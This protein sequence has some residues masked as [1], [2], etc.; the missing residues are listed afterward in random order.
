ML[1][2]IGGF[3]TYF[4]ENLGNGKGVNG[5]SVS[6]RQIRFVL[7]GFFLLFLKKR[8][9]RQSNENFGHFKLIN[10]HSIS[11]S[12]YKLV[13]YIVYVLLEIFYCLHEY[14]LLFCAAFLTFSNNFIALQYC[15]NRMN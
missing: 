8:K 15:Q 13:F 4:L 1:Y 7:F 2:I 10:F 5:I 6:Y 9:K 11:N 3:H 14:N 12:V